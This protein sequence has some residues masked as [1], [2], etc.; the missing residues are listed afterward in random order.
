MKHVCAKTWEIDE[1]VSDI[2][3]GLYV[4]NQQV[5]FSIYG[6]IPTFSIQNY[7]GSTLL[8]SG[9]VIAED[10]VLQRNDIETEDAFI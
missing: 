4:I 9:Y 2:E 1:Y 3:V 10:L 6:S 7:I 5:D 8:Q